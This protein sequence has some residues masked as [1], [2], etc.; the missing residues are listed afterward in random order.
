MPFAIKI[1]KNC[2]NFRRGD[3]LAKMYQKPS[4]D[5][6]T[7]KWSKQEY[8]T[9]MFNSTPDNEPDPLPRPEP[10]SKEPFQ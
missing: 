9:A 6:V 3:C 10:V 5:L 2:K 1:C 8:G 7:G 4:Y